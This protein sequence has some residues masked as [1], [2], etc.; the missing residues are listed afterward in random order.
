[1]HLLTAMHRVLRS[2]D[3]AP[4]MHHSFLEEMTAF[5]NTFKCIP[6]PPML[7]SY[8]GTMRSHAAEAMWKLVNKSPITCDDCSAMF[9]SDW[10]PPAGPTANDSQR[11]FSSTYMPGANLASP[12]TGAARRHRRVV[13]DD[14][15]DD[16]N[17]TDGAR[18]APA[19]ADDD[20]DAEILAD[21]DGHSARTAF[22]RLQ[23]LLAE[24]RLRAA[25]AAP[26]GSTDAFGNAP[27]HLPDYVALNPSDND[28]RGRTTAR[29]GKGTGKRKR[30]AARASFTIDARP[31]GAGGGRVRRACAFV[32]D[33]A[34]CEDD[35]DFDEDGDEDG[36]G[37]SLNGFIVQDDEEEEEESDDDD[38]DGEEDDEEDDN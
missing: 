15:D 38:D 33:Q 21:R 3:R 2:A 30:A 9:F 1:M 34:G 23:P 19:Y 7:M 4:G 29:N 24:Q 25:R 37:D 36:D 32:H 18:A 12:S 13:N 11:F 6:S 8:G 5:L 27:A 31:S 17:A 10:S 16:G 28:M 35:D 20:D 14:D 26:D 22:R